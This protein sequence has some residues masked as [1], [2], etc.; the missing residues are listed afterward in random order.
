M[1]AIK[2]PAKPQPKARPKAKA[3]A[4]P[5]PR[6]TEL[7]DEQLKQLLSLSSTSDSVELKLTVPEAMH[8]SAATA[9]GLDPLDG[10]IRLVSFFDTPDLQ[11]NKR[12]LIVRARRVQGREDDTVIKLRPVVPDEMPEK[13][14][15]APG[16]FVE[17]DAMPG[18][19]VVSA[20]MK[21]R[22]DGA[23]EV[24]RRIEGKR[25]T[26]KLFT[27]AQRA[28]YE[29]Y[30]PE[31]LGLD[32]L[33]LLGPIFVVKLNTTPPDF[34]RKLVAE[35]WLYPDGARILELSTKCKPAQMFQ[36]ALEARAFL[37]ERGID[38]SGEQQTKTASAL[39]QFSQNL[40][41]G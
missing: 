16:M 18:G 38:L 40:G 11:L 32:D 10:Q 25:A 21:A 15:R 8:R 37:T 2:T 7:G 20:S 27:K 12:G 33:T 26:R 9:L 22:L 28:F 17:L 3:K 31:G 13:F 6:L 34:R 24:K 5:T 41:T 1:T 36:V 19:Y 4:K 39:K 30:A 14:R 29:A 35:L 23:T